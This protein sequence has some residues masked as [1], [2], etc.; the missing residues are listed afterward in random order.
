MIWQPLISF[1]KVAATWLMSGWAARAIRY[2]A[3]PHTVNVTARLDSS[4][5]I[6]F[7]S[8][9]APNYESIAR[10]GIELGD[11]LPI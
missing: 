4:F 8:T 7:A 11:Q 6:K 2:I 9:L 1:A 3:V 10:L 5:V